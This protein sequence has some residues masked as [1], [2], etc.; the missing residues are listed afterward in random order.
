MNKTNTEN[1]LRKAL[2]K[3]YNLKD[4]PPKVAR[5]ATIKRIA[6]DLEKEIL[7][8]HREEVEEIKEKEVRKFWKALYKDY[9]VAISP[10]AMKRY[11]KFL[12]QYKTKEKK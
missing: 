11:Q 6:K 8:H 7:T 9:E 4:A 5:Q 1:T 3:A 12:E 10:F 2:E